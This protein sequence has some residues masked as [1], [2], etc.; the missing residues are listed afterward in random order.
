MRSVLLLRDPLAAVPAGQ[1]MVQ[2]LGLGL[3]DQ[4]IFLLH[5]LALR[6]TARWGVFHAP[7]WAYDRDVEL[8][9]EGQ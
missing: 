4:G 7:G 3:R 6:L 1:R 9:K 2:P 5:T 8:G